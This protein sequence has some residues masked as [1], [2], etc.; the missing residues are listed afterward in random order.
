MS[1]SSRHFD[2]AA[3]R[4]FFGGPVKV[5]KKAKAVNGLPLPRPATK[6]REKLEA[7][8]KRAPEVMVKV[9]SNARDSKGIVNHLRYISREGVI[10]L[11]DQNGDVHRDREGARDVL[12][13]WES[14]Y[15][16]ADHVPTVV[17][18]D[19]QK[20]G[21]RRESFHIVFSMP[22]GTPHAELQRAVRDLAAQEF[23]GH[24]YVMAFH[25]PLTDPD[26]K[27]S[28]HPHVHV[29]V[30]A[31]SSTGKRLNPR[32]ADLQ[33]WRNEF[34]AKL[35]EHG[36]DA[37]ATPRAIRGQQRPGRSQK[38]AQMA[39][40]G[41]PFTRNARRVPAA[42]AVQANRQSAASALRDWH[43]VLDTLSRSEKEG[44]RQLA[45]SLASRLNVRVSRTA[46]AKLPARDP[47]KGQDLDR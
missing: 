4:L 24:Q 6:V 18:A 29:A 38:N 46:E 37:S 34:A 42:E 21:G 23:A 15:P 33:R 3:D 27:P 40:R 41:A 7:L 35:R 14:E 8:S 31:R 43:T 20:M 36:I 16:V 39:M 30:K 1:D 13:A 2:E 25:T 11:E 10:D 19:T 47:Y 45:E 44:D 12:A 32:K 26:P 28:P 22:A 17:G 9:T 5:G